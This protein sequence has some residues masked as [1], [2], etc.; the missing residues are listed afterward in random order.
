MAKRV[1]RSR[2]K[3]ER[4]VAFMADLWEALV[5]SSELDFDKRPTTKRLEY[6]NNI[7]TAAHAAWIQC[8]SVLNRIDGTVDGEILATA[9]AA[10]DKAWNT[11]NLLVR[12]T[13]W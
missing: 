1:L 3:L 9:Q 7:K 10:K 6:L 11:Y 8:D 4:V 13:E 12:L 5:M 2:R